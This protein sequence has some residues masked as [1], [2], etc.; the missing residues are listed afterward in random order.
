MVGVVP[1]LV[2]LHLLAVIDV[3]RMLTLGGQLE[4][5]AVHGPVLV[6]SGLGLVWV[7]FILL[8]SMGGQSCGL[9]ML[10]IFFLFVWRDVG[11]SQIY[12]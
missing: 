3:V 5:G 8:F 6:G 10:F 2:G 4:V 7:F 12:N 9:F 1:C 11:S